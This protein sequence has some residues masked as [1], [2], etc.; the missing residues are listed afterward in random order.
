M[1]CRA[2]DTRSLNAATLP[3]AYR[4]AALCMT[5]GLTAVLAWGDDEDREQYK[6][7]GCNTETGMVVVCILCV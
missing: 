1:V 3:Q 6:A 7:I 2:L 4:D 5:E